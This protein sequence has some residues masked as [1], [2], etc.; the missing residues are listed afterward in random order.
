MSTCHD[1]S[2]FLLDLASSSLSWL[3]RQ[4]IVPREMMGLKD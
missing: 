3:D 2:D 4:V 1:I